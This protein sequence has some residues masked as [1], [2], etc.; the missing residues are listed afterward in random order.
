M[1]LWE[2]EMDRDELRSLK[3]QIESKSRPSPSMYLWP[4]DPYLYRIL[5][6]FEGEAV[7][8]VASGF[9]KNWKVGGYGV[10]DNGNPD[11]WPSN[12]YKSP[13]NLQIWKNWNGNRWAKQFT[14]AHQA[15][16]M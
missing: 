9:D 1:P 11:Y 15:M 7:N 5:N 8:I 14:P 2:A 3:H 10:G 4:S 13:Y 16:S 12:G 6:A